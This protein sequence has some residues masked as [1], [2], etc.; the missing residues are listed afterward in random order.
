MS[1]FLYNQQG[2]TPKYSLTEYFLIGRDSCCN[3]TVHSANDRHA[4]IEKINGQYLL[5][6]LRSTSGTLLND[7][8]INEAYLNEGDWITIE[9]CDMMFSYLPEKKRHTFSLT[10]KNEDWNNKLSQLSSVANTNFTV[11][12]LG[13]SGC[14]KD[15]LAN[16][17]HKSSK[18]SNGPFI[19]VN[20]SALS[21]SLIESELFGH[22]KGSFTSAIS[23]RK[24]AFESA[25]GGTLFLDEIGDLSPHLQA[26]L[27]RALENHEIRPVGGDH[28][29]KTDVRVIAATHQNLLNKIATND[30]R[31]DLYY[32]LNVV[33]IHTPTLF[34]R[35]EDFD[36]FLMMFAKQFKVRFDFAATQRLKKHPWPG[37]IRE[38]KNTVARAAALFGRQTVNEEMAEQ[39]LDRASMGANNQPIQDL[40]SSPLPFLK[41]MEKQLIV[42]RLAANN[43]NQRK[44]AADLGIP[45]STL[46]DRLRTYNIDP[47]TFA[48]A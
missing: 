39:I 38:L 44:T 2:T 26:K 1:A 6:D 29:I 37:N 20:C 11:L 42:K 34:E 22:V 48:S 13:P 10:S 43:G 28:T 9:N 21:E 23:D 4:K 46:H 18:R 35:I 32:R 8:K 7:Q 45:K 36:G 25:R 16:E 41:E 12:L 5:K 24:G 3:W 19:S 14:G 17:I 40:N 33:S 31:A 27:L 15:V 30:F 47:R